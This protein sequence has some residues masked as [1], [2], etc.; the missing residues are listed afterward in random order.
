M[1]DHSPSRP[2]SFAAALLLSAC[3]GGHDHGDHGHDHGEKGHDHEH[4]G[5]AEASPAPAHDHG[6]HEHAPSR[7]GV[8]TEVDGLHIEA[9]AMP[10]GLWFWFSDASHAAVDAAALQASV[11]VRQGDA[12]FEGPL[13]R[14]TGAARWD[15]ALKGDQPVTVVLNFSHGGKAQA[16]TFQFSTASLP[17]HDHRALHGGQVGMA[18]DVHV[19]W[20]PKEGA[21][22][23]FISGADR[24][25]TKATLSGTLE[26]G[27][28][29][30]PL[31]WDEGSRAL[32]ADAADAGKGPIVVEIAGASPAPVRVAFQPVGAG[33]SGHDHGAHG[34]DGG[35]DHGDA[36][37]D[38][39]GGHDHGAHAH[40][41]A[42]HDHG[43][44][45]PA[46]DGGHD[47]GGHDH[48]R[49][50]HGGHGHDHT[51]ASPATPA[52]K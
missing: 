50:D 45:K 37:H 31:R 15:G 4:Q 47:H 6:A 32:V 10:D 33:A 43:S 26:V 24:T 25:E 44:E 38:H 35:H 27:E 48:G 51:E 16:A 23:F 12:R 28:Q 18:G 30:L 2:L 49:H 41:D 13:S 7:G 22:R 39:D 34:H 9:L 36:G 3:G 8:L 29:K 42:G 5:K 19:E 46:H 1:S 21:H 40:G 20:A 11:I 17:L 14:R 52:G